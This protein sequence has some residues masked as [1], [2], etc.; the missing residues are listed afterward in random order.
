ML[1]AMYAHPCIAKREKLWDY[2][3]FVGANHNMPWLIV[4]DFN[5]MLRFE[6]KLGGASLCRFKR[7]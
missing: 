6:D 2:L 3:S 5:E 4:G 1:T 7:V